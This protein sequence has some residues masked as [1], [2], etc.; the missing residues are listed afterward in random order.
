VTGNNVADEPEYDTLMRGLPPTQL[1]VIGKP[2]LRER[3]PS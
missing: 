1:M 3:M 2:E